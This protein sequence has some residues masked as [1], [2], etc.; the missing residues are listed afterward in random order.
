M[1]GD[2]RYSADG[3]EG[4]WAQDGAAW[5]YY[6]KAGNLVA[7]YQQTHAGDPAVSGSL[8]LEARRTAGFNLGLFSWRRDRSVATTVYLKAAAR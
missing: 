4:R 2:D 1:T 6:D 7:M 5:S 8:I 3:A